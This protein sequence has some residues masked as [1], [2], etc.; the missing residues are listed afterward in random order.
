[1]KTVACLYTKG[2][3]FDQDYV[4]RL[5]EGVREHCH[6]DYEFVCLTNE[7]VPGVK[8]LALGRSLGGWWN[9]L[10]LFTPGLLQGD[11]TYFDLDTMIVGD[12]TD[13][14]AAPYHFAAANRWKHGPDELNSTVMKWNAFHDFGYLLTSYDK[15]AARRYAPGRRRVGDQAWIEDHLRDLFT[16]LGEDFPG[17]IVSYKLHVQ[18]K[19][20][21]PGAAVV[22]FHG[23]PRPRDIGW[24]L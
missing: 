1:M 2:A 23:T 24:K 17:L 18:G 13:L 3:G 4:W 7:N 12:I 11:V 10:Q 9:K 19:G 8:C 5:Q 14:V 20:V 16:N 6:T 21:P 15:E 22:A